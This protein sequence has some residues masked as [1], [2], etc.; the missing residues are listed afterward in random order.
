MDSFLSSSST[1][2]SNSTN[3]TAKN[4]PST[5]STTCGP[6]AFNFFTIRRS[7]IPSFLANLSAL[8][9]ANPNGNGTN[10]APGTGGWGGQQPG[11]VGSVNA[12]AAAAGMIVPELPGK[13]VEPPVG[14]LLGE[15]SFSLPSGNPFCKVTGSYDLTLNGK[16]GFARVNMQMGLY[17]DAKAAGEVQEKIEFAG[18]LNFYIKTKTTPIWRKYW[19]VLKDHVLE[20]YDFMYKE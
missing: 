11:G 5:S 14:A 4:P 20:V 12:S 16:K 13:M 8:S 6:N 19:C 3:N 7:N 1:A 17:L 18:Y 2:A 10:T 15:L 9:A